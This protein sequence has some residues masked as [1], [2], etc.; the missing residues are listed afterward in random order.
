MSLAYLN[1]QEHITNKY[2]TVCWRS[3]EQMSTRDLA[4]EPVPDD[5]LRVAVWWYCA[6]CNEWH[7]GVHKPK[8]S[9]W[10]IRPLIPAT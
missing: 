10:L 8:D 7:V 6:N 9:M 3:G 2:L 1:L 5:S 4:F